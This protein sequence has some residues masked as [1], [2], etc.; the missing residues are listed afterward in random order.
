MQNGS[1]ITFYT[2]TPRSPWKG[3]IISLSEHSAFVAFD[4]IERHDGTMTT[5]APTVICRTRILE[6]Q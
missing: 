4:P 6:V 1:A 3:K 5:P 2:D